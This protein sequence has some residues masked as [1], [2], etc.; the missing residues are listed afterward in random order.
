M[1]IFS[2]KKSQG[3]LSNYPFWICFTIAIGIVSLIIVKI[4]NVGVDEA[5]R[6]P[7]DVE[8]KISL[9]PR[10][11]SSG[12]CFAYTDDVGRVHAR[13]IDANE[14]ENVNMGNCFQRSDVRYAFSIS[15]EVLGVVN[16]GPIN[17]FNWEGG[18]ASKEIKEDVI[19]FDRIMVGGELEDKL[20]Q[21]K[22]I[23]GIKD[24]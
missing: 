4:A 16:K 9:I 7:K 5:S 24:A 8:D 10:F 3:A 1:K 21:G 11:Y 2:H 12:D 15:L 18:P 17:T 19:V 14:F 13:V 20:Y 22:L 23:I 6:I